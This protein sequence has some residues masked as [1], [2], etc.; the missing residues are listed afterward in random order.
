VQESPVL[1]FVCVWHES[2]FY[3]IWKVVVPYK[4]L[5]VRLSSLAEWARLVRRASEAVAISPWN[6]DQKVF[7]ENMNI[8]FV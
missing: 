7:P 5:V 2:K 4:K 1:L 3:Y 6:C 8:H